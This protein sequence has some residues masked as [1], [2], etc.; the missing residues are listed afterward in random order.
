MADNVAITAGSGTSIA[1]D[2]VGGAHYQRVKL[3]LGADGAAAD[4]P[5]GAGTESGVL[6]V[7]LPTDG[8]GQAKAVGDVA[9]D[10]ADSGSPVK[11]GAVATSTNPTAVADGDRT[12]LRADLL[13]KLMIRAGSARSLI[14][15]GYVQLI[16][17]NTSETT[18]L[19]AGGA[20]VFHDITALSLSNSNGT[21][22]TVV[23]IRDATAGS[24]VLVVSLAARAAIHLAWHVP[25]KQTT[26]NNNWTIQQSAA[27]QVEA[28]IQCEKVTA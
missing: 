6:R 2:D 14:T 15:Q 20:G 13:G 4:A 19:A 1:T 28:T 5:T 8:T 10:A 22:G 9:H 25:F 7:T 11:I 12:N 18:L 16:T 27:G 26:A 21:T 23:T 24:A 17:S 3:A